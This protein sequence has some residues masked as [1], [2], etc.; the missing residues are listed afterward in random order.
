MS[1]KGGVVLV[2]FLLLAS[3]FLAPHASVDV[4][5]H[6]PESMVLEYDLENQ[7]LAV[8]I[9]HVVANVNNHYIERVS[10]RRNGVLWVERTY[11][12]QPSR[13][14]FTYVYSV[15]GN[16]GDF[17]HVTAY[18]SVEGSIVESLTVVSKP[19][20]PR[21]M[22]ALAGD[23]HALLWW[24]SPV[25]TGGVDLLGYNIYRSAGDDD[26]ILLDQT[27][28][29]DYVDASAINGQYYLYAVSAV[30][31]LGEGPISS[32]VGAKPAP[33]KPMAV[34]SNDGFGRFFVGEGTRDNPWVLQNRV[35]DATGYS[36][37]I[38]VMGTTDHFV[39][40]NNTITG[41]SFTRPLGTASGI[42]LRNVEN[43]RVENNII[44]ENLG[45]GVFAEHSRHVNI[46][47]NTISSSNTG[48]YSFHNQH[49][50]VRDNAI[51]PL[52]ENLPMANE[53]QD[54]ERAG[55][56]A[57]GFEIDG[58]ETSKFETN[59]FETSE[60]E[61]NG[62]ETSEFEPSGFE[63]G[64]TI[65]GGEEKTAP[66]K[67]GVV[68]FKYSHESPLTLL[69][70]A[71][72]F[73]IKRN[74][75]SVLSSIFS[76]PMPAMSPVGPAIPGTPLSI[77]M[78]TGGRVAGLFPSFKLGVL[79][80]A[81]ST[82]QSPHPSVEDA[83]SMLLA[84]PGIEYAEP[85]YLVEYDAVPND[86]NY[87]L[88]WALP[89]MDLPSA[90]DVTTG[91]ED[92]VV[93]VI[94][95]GV[96]LN[97]PDIV[98]NLWT[99]P[100]G[101]HGY[102]ASTGGFF[103]MD[104]YGHGT[105]V[106][107]ILGAVGNNGMGV[108]GVNWDVGI[109]VLR[110]GNAPSTLSA[111]D[112]MNYVLQHRNEG[113]NV[114]ATSNSWG[115]SFSRSLY[116]AIASHRDA[117]ILFVAS[118]GNSQMNT[119]IQAHY[120]SGYNLTNIISVAASDSQDRLASFSNYGMG[121]VHLAAPGVNI[122][123]TYLN[124]TYAY[125]Q[126]TSM[127]APQVSG[128]AALLSAANP[129]Y[130]MNHLKNALLSTA[131]PLPA[132]ESRTISE[133]RVSASNAFGPREPELNVHI[134][135]LGDGKAF[136][137]GTSSDFFVSVNDGIIPIPG[138]NVSVTFS[139]EETVLW[140]LD[141]GVGTDQVQGDGYYSARWT[142]RTSG[143]QEV[144][145]T[146]KAPD[147]QEK[148][149]GFQINVWS[150]SGIRLEETA[151]SNIS[152][153][154]VH[155]NHNGLLLFGGHDNNIEHCLLS[156]NRLRAIYISSS[157]NT[158]ISKS[159]AVD[160]G[161]PPYLVP[162]IHV[163]YATSTTIYRT[164]ISGSWPGAGILIVGSNDTHVN[165]CT[166]NLNHNGV[167]IENSAFTN[168]S[169][170][171]LAK[172]GFAGIVA[173]GFSTDNIFHNNSMTG[174]QYGIYMENAA[175][176]SAT[177]NH[178]HYMNAGI[179]A[180]KASHSLISDN[181]IT[182]IN[183]TGLYIMQSNG[184][185]VQDNTIS[186]C[187]STGLWLDHVSETILERNN[188]TGNNLGIASKA[189]HNISFVDLMLE[190]QPD[191]MG[192]RLET[193]SN[194]SFGRLRMTGGKEDMQIISSENIGI[195]DGSLAPDTN[196]I[197]FRLE[198][199]SN[200]HLLN[201]PLTSYGEEKNVLSPGSVIEIE[202][203]L[204]IAI[205]DSYDAGAK[206]VKGANLTV[207]DAGDVVVHHDPF[208]IPDVVL[209]LPFKTL[210]GTEHGLNSTVFGPYFVEAKKEIENGMLH[211]HA[212]VYLEQDVLKTLAIRNTPPFASLSF[213]TLELDEDT[214]A[215]ID[216]WD[217]FHDWDGMETLSFSTE[218]LHVLE[219]STGDPGANI[220]LEGFG[221]RTLQARPLKD[222]YGREVHRVFAS[223]GQ[224]V[225]YQD[226]DVVVLPV[227]DAPRLV[228][229][230]PD[231]VLEEGSSLEYG[232]LSQYFYDIEGDPINF[233]ILSTNLNFTAGIREDNTL[234]IQSFLGWW[235][236]EE[237]H[238]RVQDDRGAYIEVFIGV[239][240]TRY[241]H[242]PAAD[243]ML[244]YEMPWNTQASKIMNLY[245]YF[246]DP[247]DYPN[248]L[249][250][251]YASTNPNI[252][253]SISNGWV[254]LKPK[255]DWHGSATVEFTASDGGKS[256]ST[257]WS[258]TVKYVNRP[259]TI[260]SPIP[261]VSLEEGST[262]SNFFCLDD[263]FEDSDNVLSFI[264][265]GNK[266]VQITIGTGNWVTFHAPDGW[267]GTETVTFRASDGESYV[268]DHSVVNVT[269]RE[270]PPVW[271]TALPS[272][273]MM[274]DEILQEW[275]DLLDYVTDPDTP[276]SSLFF[277]VER[278]GVH[279]LLELE[280]SVL[281]ILPPAGW[282]GQDSAIL[283]VSDGV[284]SASAML[285]INVE[286]RIPPPAAFISQP[287]DGGRHLS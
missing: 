199:S 239:K 250:F 26:W 257:T 280:G 12:S 105:H 286:R 203:R 171:I 89:K 287:E 33:D 32:P 55:W 72:E 181:V 272:A 274:Q 54:G 11:N 260:T 125:F 223:D 129:E 104:S 110:M 127:A 248:P 86:P 28:T 92:V 114:V 151:W 259:P 159:F 180:A 146:V 148:T 112:C 190:M 217:H 252:G 160:N 9:T 255:A 236:S 185:T 128:L 57:S 118:A 264:V 5:A 64:E 20:Q 99:S 77:E 155:A 161:A 96:D 158:I 273:E 176:T 178:M 133:G 8:T 94:D 69:E 246:N 219:T 95:S 249:V 17:L 184:S 108:A 50:E 263:H 144:F 212:T 15:T 213:S 165:E 109:M 226:L 132:F 93:A 204:I 117:E 261:D 62:F 116:D 36:Y 101:H 27:S 68:L 168:V 141:H 183:G 269:R 157:V 84:E 138:A 216:L 79:A 169:N 143:P 221:G 276:M 253:L 256:A 80:L 278:Q 82:A 232:S 194:M 284:H 175:R 229:S 135:G 218:L 131:A 209:E 154:S 91:S 201:T 241:N 210:L 25:N 195:S 149:F 262:L 196:G 83:I 43:A 275:V 251:T 145:V 163:H 40:R 182:S 198:G 237:L 136:N 244:P 63:T 167:Y 243:G 7:T 179:R 4:S 230:L 65:F 41:A 238:I 19:G 44:S 24:D 265:R 193:S 30:N 97:H 211:D 59:G 271:T 220:A 164:Q 88:Q 188:L 156:G 162:G 90:W 113:V 66:Y 126:G 281:S 67:E 147:F 111:I 208:S 186:F 87:N 49:V 283:N 6:A 225:A 227:N 120:P 102:D 266:N 270:R 139:R 58:F 254:S 191:K 247:D 242:P 98:D 46:T 39:V 35:M 224:Y 258:V 60:F 76:Q 70:D 215:S 166:I 100:Q 51:N 14:T 277:S 192:M 13:T 222:W 137:L 234:K 45:F 53:Y 134:S 189:S 48:I 3:C 119:D 106:A 235:G 268:E 23:S 16:P 18:C 56:D 228:S 233:Q 61:T 52:H 231:A 121:S 21:N 170:S 1:C 140:P 240:V 29:I 47:G 130:D 107:G 81:P 22:D 282:H 150:V 197:H 74:P 207:Y 124:G 42:Y 71:L 174:Q 10:V 206:P 187:T 38:L 245:D 172:N 37:G 85:D 279:V 202:N 73:E 285:S 122:Y 205:R 200:L 123:S 214:T 173:L 31:S 153:N 177:S 34:V 152:H 142:A 2:A 267:W 115:T 75:S 103:P 78:R